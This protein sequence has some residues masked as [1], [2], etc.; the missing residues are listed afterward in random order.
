MK[1]ISFYGILTV[2]VLAMLSVG[3]TSCGDDD[4]ADYPIEGEWVIRS[5]TWSHYIKGG[6]IE[7]PTKEAK[8]YDET[9]TRGLTITAS[10]N[11][12]TIVSTTPGMGGTYSQTGTNEY[13]DEYGE[14]RL[15]I[16]SVSGS[17]LTIAWYED[18][19]TN[20]DGKR[21]E[22]GLLIFEKK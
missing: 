18:Y 20:S 6:E 22:Y 14:N 17:V 11:K 3:F 4:D 15:V 1:R 21:D 10:G 13:K 9:E 2:V 12:Y 16:K 19:Y 8:V 7:S 5:I